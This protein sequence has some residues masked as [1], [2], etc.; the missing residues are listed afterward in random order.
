MATV[1]ERKDNSEVH[2]CTVIDLTKTFVILGTLKLIYK[3]HSQ[4]DKI[5]VKQPNRKIGL[6]QSSVY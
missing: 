5:N 4:M 6:R 2:N 3:E 1:F